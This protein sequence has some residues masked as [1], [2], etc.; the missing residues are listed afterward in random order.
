MQKETKNTQEPDLITQKGNKKYTIT[1][2]IFTP[3]LIISDLITQKP[4]PKFFT[5]VVD[6]V[7]EHQIPQPN[8]SGGDGERGSNTGTYR[9]KQ[10]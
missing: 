3:E 8:K 10:L 4:K 5:F 7:K 1:K 2:I 6:N 9:A